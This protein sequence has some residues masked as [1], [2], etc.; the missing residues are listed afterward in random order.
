MQPEQS[1]LDK[2]Q[3]ERQ[4]KSKKNQVTDFMRSRNIE[5]MTEDRSM[6]FANE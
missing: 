3:R 1:I 2:I 6:A 5:D 4:Q